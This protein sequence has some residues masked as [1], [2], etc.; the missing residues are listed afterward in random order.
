MT[1]DI[2]DRGRL[3]RS[4]TTLVTSGI[5]AAGLMTV[6][7]APASAALTCGQPDIDRN[8]WSADRVT[9]ICKGK[10][11][12]DLYAKTWEGEE[13]HWVRSVPKAGMC[14]LFNVPG[15]VRSVKVKVN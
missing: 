8:V 14:Y 5:L 3:R 15:H 13:F 7:A 9:I 4:L 1:K 10:G 6:G 11:R 12:L 2:R